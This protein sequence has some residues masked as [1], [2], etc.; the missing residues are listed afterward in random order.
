VR[1]DISVTF[2]EGLLRIQAERK[3]EKN[4]DNEK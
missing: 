4:E 1:A 3:E 2:D